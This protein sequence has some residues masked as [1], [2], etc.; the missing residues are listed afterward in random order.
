[1]AIASIVITSVIASMVRVVGENWNGNRLVDGDADLFH[2]GNIN[3]VSLLHGNG[4]GSVNC[5][6]IGLGNLD[7][8]GH[9]VGFLNNVGLGNVDDVWAGNL[10]FVVDWVGFLHFNGIRDWH[11]LRYWDFFVYWHIL[12]NYMRNGDGLGNWNALVYGNGFV[13]W[14][15][16]GLG[17]RLRDRDGS[18]DL[19]DNHAGGV[20]TVA[21]ITG[22]ITSSSITSSSITSS[23]ISSETSSISS[24]IVPIPTEVGGGRET[25]DGDKNTAE[26][27][28]PSASAL[29]WWCCLSSGFR[30]R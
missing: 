19:V 27:S 29:V 20:V 14:H 18:G 2:D 6:F 7:V 11:F 16:V 25:D 17:H 22:S 12:F 28:R 8:D 24:T 5:N 3:G 13:H 4:V 15:D 1:V 26:P 23:S 30:G 21:T 10:N 9:V